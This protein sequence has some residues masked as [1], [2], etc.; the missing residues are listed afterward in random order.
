MRQGVARQELDLAGEDHDV[1]AVG[2]AVEVQRDL[3][4]R[5][6]MLDHLG[7]RKRAEPAGFLET[8]TTHQAKQET[9]G[10]QIAGSGGIDHARDRIGRHRDHAVT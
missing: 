5:A 2:R 1:A 7:R 3:R 8:R 6:D 9:G 10:E 4:P